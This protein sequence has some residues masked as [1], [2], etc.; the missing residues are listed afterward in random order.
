MNDVHVVPAEEYFQ[1]LLREVPRAKKRIVLAAMVLVWGERT[2]PIF[3]M[4]QDALARGVRVTVL[5][6]NFTRLTYLNGLKPV[7][8]RT[9]RIK[10][11]F[12]ALKELAGKGAHIYTVGKVG[13][14]PHKGRCHIKVTVIDNHSFSFG[15]VNFVDQAFKLH[16]YMLHSEKPEV[17]D[18]LE[19]LVD[20]VGKAKAS[21]N[22]GEV[23]FGSDSVLFDGG[24]RKQSIIYD[25]AVEL[26]STATR[27]WYVS[28]LV[29]SGKLA[30]ALN[31]IDT[32]FYYN[33]PEQMIVPDSWAQAYD[34]QKHRV[35]N[36][37]E[38]KNPIH[39]KFILFEQKDGEK[40]LLS[41]SHNFSY[42]G[43]SFGTKEIAL[44][45][46]NQKLW[47]ELRTFIKTHITKSSGDKTNTGE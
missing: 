38:G 29:P 46:T 26:A 36:R 4:L 23:A 37:Y 1:M 30:T 41:G 40:V 10:Q 45:S 20:R 14:P 9:K 19:Q 43:V 11:T 7:A 32:A 27:A 28:H 34:E 25:R 13:F 42:R 8:T 31:K 3:I 33:R 44:C 24:K 39:A 22:D 2:A 17:A 16:D 6:D 12:T 15:G 5:L 35:S 18:C 47:N 21:L